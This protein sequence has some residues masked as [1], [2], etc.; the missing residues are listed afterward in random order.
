MYSVRNRVNANEGHL[1]Y[2]D[3]DLGS[4]DSVV[5]CVV[6]KTAYKSPHEK[7]ALESLNEAGPV[8]MTKRLTGKSG[9][10]A[11]GV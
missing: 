10:V 7:A 6:C 11:L 1:L 4:R 8:L 5:I 3:C 9:V 2:E